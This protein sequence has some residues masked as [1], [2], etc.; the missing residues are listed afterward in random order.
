[1]PTPVKELYFDKKEIKII[2]K[3]LNPVPR[4]EFEKHRRD[5]YKF[6]DYYSLVEFYDETHQSYCLSNKGKQY[7]EYQKESSAQY[8][9]SLA[10]SI[11]AI[12]VSVIAIAF[13]FLAN[14]TEIRTAAHELLTL[15][16]K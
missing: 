9:L 6:L 10:L 14:F 8:R 1:M 11:I 12:I 15:M 5:K 2:K 7:L 13:T 16:L 3:F 4:E